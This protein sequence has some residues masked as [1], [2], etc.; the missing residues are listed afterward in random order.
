MYCFV[1]LLL[2]SILC[3]Q[4]LGEKNKEI[5]I[6]HDLLSKK[7]N[8]HNELIK[9]L[10]EN[11]KLK[12][13][14]N[15]KIKSLQTDIDGLQATLDKHVKEYNKM[16]KDKNL[17][18]KNHDEKCEDIR[19]KE[20]V[21][22]KTES[23]ANVLIP[24]VVED[25]IKQLQDTVEKLAKDVEALKKLVKNPEEKMSSGEAT[26]KAAETDHHVIE[27]TAAQAQF[28]EASKWLGKDEEEDIKKGIVG[29]KE[30]AQQYCREP[31]ALNAYVQ[32]AKGYRKLAQW[33]LAIENY[34][35]VLDQS[36]ATIFQKAE[37]YLGKAEAERQKNDR[38]KACKTLDALEQSNIPLSK[39]QNIRY[40]ELIVACDCASKRD[41]DMKEDQQSKD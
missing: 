27:F 7:V 14:L 28:N 36:T 1:L 4:D 39:D 2:S 30:I 12:S 33:D 5:S 25:Q 38:V 26:K 23:T 32:I 31:I 13:S 6:V 40:Q 16:I 37:S 35:Y 17:N 15:E 3:G 24:N 41:K 21:D 11:P 9:Q 10:Q 34:Q 22:K 18:P 20:E 8:E 19:K 29:F